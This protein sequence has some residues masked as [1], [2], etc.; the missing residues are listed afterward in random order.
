LISGKDADGA[1]GDEGVAFH[2]AD[3]D[4]DGCFFCWF[5]GRMLMSL[6]LLME[7]LIAMAVLW[8]LSRHATVLLHPDS[9]LFLLHAMVA[10][11]FPRYVSVPPPYL[12]AYR[13]EVAGWG[14]LLA[15]DTLDGLGRLHALLATSFRCYVSVPCP[16]F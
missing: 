16:H 12:H 10:A 11:S 13:I 4:S 7:L 6:L 14:L 1:A 5:L 3:A 8:W 9:F 15:F 2:E